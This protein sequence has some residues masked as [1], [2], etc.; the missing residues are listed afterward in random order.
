AAE[1]EA[2]PPP[3]MPPQ[4]V[5]PGDDD[6]LPPPPT[7]GQEDGQLPPGAPPAAMRGP[8]QPGPLPEG[9][10]LDRLRQDNPKEF[11]RLS[12]LRSKNP[13]QF[14]KE[15]RNLLGGRMFTG[16]QTEE[17]KA[18]QELAAKYRAAKSDAE[19]TALRAEIKTAVNKAFEKRLASQRQRLAE[20][21]KQLSKI[22]DQVKQREADRDTICARRVEELTRDPRYNW[23]GG[24]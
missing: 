13:E 18:C 14:R 21:E 19:K 11:A 9:R 8:H 22:R 20:L 6:V 12:E 3:P 2:M 23:G 7:A 5:P 17:D 15:V 1:D 24:E 4:P 16:R 10:L